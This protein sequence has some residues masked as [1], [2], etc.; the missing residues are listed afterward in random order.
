MK[1]NPRDV[2]SFAL[3]GFAVNPIYEY[4]AYQMQRIIYGKP[5]PTDKLQVQEDCLLEA[6]R[7]SDCQLQIAVVK[8]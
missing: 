8:S 4:H 6:G 3:V 2:V 7:N 5:N 1:P